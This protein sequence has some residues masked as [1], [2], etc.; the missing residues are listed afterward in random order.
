MISLS[1]LWTVF[2]RELSAYFNAA[3]AYIF[4]IVFVFLNGGL[5]MTQFFLYARAE[6]RPFF[7]TLPYTLAVF[8]PAVSM[9]LWAEERK[10]NT[11]ELLLTFPMGTQ[12]LV[13]GKFLAGLVFYIAALA[14]TLTIPLMLTMI[15]RPDMGGIIGGYLGAILLGGFFLAAGIFVS[16]LCR[17]QIVA[18]IVSMMICFGIHLT[19]TEFVASSIDSWVPGLGSFLRH[20]I[21]SF[22]HYESFGKGVID[23][24]D[25]LYFLIG[26]G[27]FLTLNGFWLEG[28]MRPG[29]KKIFSTA[30]VI[31]AG[32]FL[33]S[34][35]L[36]AELTLGRFD[37]TEQKTYT[38][39]ESTR[40]ILR[41]LKAPV[42]AKFYVSPVDKMPTGMKTIEQD[43]IDKLQELSIASG[44]K[45]SYKIFHMEAANITNPQNQKTDSLEQQISQKGI[46][47]FQVRAIESDEVN[48]KLVYAA[49]SI[50]YK[51]KADEVIPQIVPQNLHELEYSIVSKIYRMS[52]PENPKIAIVAPFTE[53]QVEPE[54]AGLL[55]QLGGQ[56]PDMMRD[57]PYE[58]LGMALN[59]EGYQTERI[60]LTEKEP[61]P[62]DAKTLIL[63]EPLKL[64]DRQRFE[65]S[66]FVAGGGSL[67]LAVQN[68]DYQYQ[69]S[70]GTDLSITARYKEPGVNSLLK[71]WGLEVDEQ[72][73]ADAQNDVIN[74]SGGARIG[75]FEVSVPV[76]TPIQILVT[77]SGMNPDVSMTSNLSTLFYLW[78]SALKIDESKIKSLNLKVE[79]LLRSTPQSWTVPFKEGMLGPQDL[80]RIPESK[81]GPFPLAVL[82]EG[83]FTDIFAGKDVPEWPKEES[84]APAAGDAAAAEPVQ[85]KS[86]EA[87]KPG[88]VTPAPGKVLLTGAA[89][90]LQKHLFRGGGHMNFFMN[91]VD[92]ITLGNELVSIRSKQPSDRS[93]GR[94]SA[95]AKIGWRF[96][97]S[98]VLP[99]IIAFIG[100]F[101]MILR[102]RAKQNYMKDF[103]LS[104]K[105]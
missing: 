20:F 99:V 27:I 103:V 79:T 22:G 80:V 59:Y 2:K 14:A 39:G 10:G 97:V 41:E 45:F 1:N 104:E 21:G 38:I 24:R 100:T 62:D 43:V 29:A 13:L 28:R 4:I 63:V 51:E 25:L 31:A 70:G 56:M 87:P 89:T 64:N 54:L 91:A 94:V 66:R 36:F 75:P 86:V 96:F 11:L 3:I 85:D 57:D 76:K 44:G 33:M 60:K 58:L 83:Q 42:T 9:R 67:F 74:L 48:V 37:L 12:T 50:G 90:M 82:A 95:G 68:Y 23:N 30:A 93:I 101:R 98:V 34:N 61:L 17:D 102:R 73:L 18:F 26:T 46:Q 88:P 19:G 15:G 52:L 55:A 8:L 40:K 6:M 49:V 65:I 32:I 105:S 5:F 69:P 72:I 71:E 81:V 35:W 78:G 47:P 92:A 84:P 77:E 53:K 7:L 16:G